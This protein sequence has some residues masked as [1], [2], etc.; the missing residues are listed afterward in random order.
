M[1]T[2]VDRP[3]RAPQLTLSVVAALVLV[4]GVFPPAVHGGAPPSPS[5]G[6]S[7]TETGTP[8]PTV[9]PSGGPTSPA[10]FTPSPI[11]TA[12]PTS[13]SHTG[14][15]A[16]A[17]PAASAISTVTPTVD[18]TGFPTTTSPTP[19]PMTPTATATPIG[20]CG[21]LQVDSG[22]TCDP[23]GSLQ[24]PNNAPCRADCTYCGDMITQVADGESCDDANSVSGCRPDRP[25]F[26]LD[27]CLNNCEFPIC[28]DPSRIQL[29]PDRYD[30]VQVHGRLIA[31]TEVDFL[32]GEFHVHI[33]RR[34]CFHDA[35]VACETDAQCDAL[36]SGST[37]TERLVFE[38]AVDGSAM[39]GNAK[40]WKYRDTAAKT[41][42]GLYAVKI[43]SKTT[44]KAC[45]GGP[46]QGARC[47]SAGDCPQGSCLG[48]YTLKLK[49]YGDV[50]DAA[51]DMQTRIFGGG[52]G[53]A[54]RGIWQQFPKGWRL[55]KKS[56]LLD[57]YL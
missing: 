16:T 45:A 13:V 40:R 18:V 41:A 20:P 57:P 11:A 19:A 38:R 34:N 52:Y 35:S 5:P 28:E 30:V 29:Y 27:A 4:L 36:S 42:G 3:I 17:T 56:E 21:N 47:T 44:K 31:P 25:Q 24:P 1:M 22:E 46:S 49:A 39:T 37:C 6:V 26:A 43:T 48:Y 12:T 55:Y 15:T 53:W 50:T 8:A 32:S 7:P 23:P 10:T 14:S 33:S 54:V 2:D 9:G 51:F